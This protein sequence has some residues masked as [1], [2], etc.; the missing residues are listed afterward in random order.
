MQT[1]LKNIEEKLQTAGGDDKPGSSNY[2]SKL[3]EDLIQLNTMVEASTSVILLVRTTSYSSCGM[4]HRR[5][6]RSHSMALGT[7]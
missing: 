5:I 6:S 7:L 3:L 2:I 4:N 1:V